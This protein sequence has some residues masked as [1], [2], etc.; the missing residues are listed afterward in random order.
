MLTAVPPTT[1]AAV[2]VIIAAVYSEM[3]HHRPNHPSTIHNMHEL[4]IYYIR[5]LV[6]V[7]CPLPKILPFTI[8]IRQLWPVVPCP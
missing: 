4:S 8:I 1:I 5:V 6:V 7:V 3:R 2:I